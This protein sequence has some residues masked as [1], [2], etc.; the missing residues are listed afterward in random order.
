MAQK[1]HPS[2]LRLRTT[3][4]HLSSWY[5]RRKYAELLHCDLHLRTGLSHILRSSRRRRQLK[6]ASAPPH[7]FGGLHTTMSPLGISVVSLVG[8]P[9]QRGD[10]LR[11][12]SV[13][14]SPV[15]TQP[16]SPKETL[17]TLLTTLFA[18]RERQHKL[19]V[20]PLSYQRTLACV[21]SHAHEATGN[22]KAWLPS[23]VESARAQHWWVRSLTPVAAHSIFQTAELC[24]QS[25]AHRLRNGDRVRSLMHRVVREAQQCS[26]VQGFR[27]KV[28][29][30]IQG[31]EIAQSLTKSYGQLKSTSFDKSVDHGKLQVWTPSGVLGLQVTLCYR[32]T[33]QTPDAFVLPGVAK[34]I[35]SLNT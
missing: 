4:S 2:Q 29:G 8:L 20:Q 15:K 7:F 25:L 30:R 34:P 6:T 19:G 16:I 12:P 23:F 22:E 10:L 9:H 26:W 13:S 5:S 17:V 21:Q 24:L 18:L 1:A 35:G 31:A 28:S 27:V 11:R 3:R 14:R 32:H 33:A